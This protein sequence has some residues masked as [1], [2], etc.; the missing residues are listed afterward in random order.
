M[1]LAIQLEQE[2]ALRVQ[3]VNQFVEKYLSDMDLP[4]GQAIAELRK[5]MLYSATN[6]GKRFRP[7][8]SLLVAELFNC[9]VQKV[10]PFATAVEFIHTYSL[11]HDDLPCMDNDDIRR[12]KPTN[13]KVFGEDFALLAGDALL[14]EAFMLLAKNYSDSGFLIGRL[15]ELL[16]DAAGL[17]GMVGGQAIDLR[18][19]HKPMS[20]EELTHLHRLKTGALIRLSVEGAATIAGAKPSEIE[21]LKKFGEGLGLAFQVADDVLDHGEKD[22]DVRSFTGILGLD[23]TKEYL[24]KISK[25]TLAELHKVSAEAPMLEYLIN[26][27]QNRQV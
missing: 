1:D 15:T 3:T 16:S 12:G 20:L 7:V 4:K 9:P 18:A 23:G 11:I 8:L 6:G 19:G 10:L 26:F 2:M 22:Q 14:T 5:S 27:N 13:H 17:R 24:Q 21:S 25:E